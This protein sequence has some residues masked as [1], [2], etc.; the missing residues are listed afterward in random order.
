VRSDVTGAGPRLPIPVHDPDAVRETARQILARPEFAHHGP[1]L[2][3]RL[4]RWVGDVIGHLFDRLSAGG[5]SAAGWVILVVAVVAAIYALT[6][7][8][9]KVQRD[10]AQADIAVTAERRPA[11]AWRDE[12]ERLERD[13]RWKEAMRARYRALVGTLVER[14]VVDDV[15]GRTTGEYRREVADAAP[16]T[17]AEFAGAT[18]LFERA[19]YGDEPTGAAEAAH[20]G[21]LAERVLTGVGR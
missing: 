4:E 2:V 9:R 14:G 19:W 16:S 6:R 1:S 15:A 12:A 5:S 7:A 10:P 8:G 17:A 3:E 13:G 18:E 21:S 20:F 11:S